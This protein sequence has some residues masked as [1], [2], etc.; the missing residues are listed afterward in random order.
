MSRSLVFLREAVP[1]DAP[2]LAEL[3]ARRAAARRRDRPRRRPVRVVEAAAQDPDQRLVVAEYDGRLAGGVHL[4]L[5]TISPLNLDLSV[6][7]MSPTGVPGVPAPRRR[8]GPDG[9]RRR[10][11]GGARRGP[12]RERGASGSRDGNRFMARLALGPVATLRLAPT[13]VVRAKLMAQRPPVARVPRGSSPTCSPYAAR[14]AARGPA[15]P[16]PA[17]RHAEPPRPA[18]TGAGPRSAPPRGTTA[19][20]RRSRT[21]ARPALATGPDRWQALRDPITVRRRPGRERGRRAPARRRPR[22]PR[23]AAADA[24]AA[25]PQVAERRRAQRRRRSRPWGEGR[26]A[27]RARGDQGTA[28]RTRDW[29]E[30]VHASALERC[31]RPTSPCGSPTRWWSRC[32]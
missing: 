8:P 29:C 22:R 6:Q 13:T 12:C 24:Q 31:S 2:R 4:R 1:A 27:G 25:H 9:R 17:P 23:R 16:R 32:A 19:R 11:G 14:C 28:E 5:T 15:A 26:P 21:A 18:R 10:L 30:R 3:W 7:V 20:R